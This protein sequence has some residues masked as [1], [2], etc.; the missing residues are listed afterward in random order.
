MKN[1]G[2]LVVLSGPSGSGKD[3][4]LIEF[5]QN[6]PQVKKSISMTTREIRDG[7][8]DGKD[9]YFVSDEE[10]DKNINDGMMLEF[11]RYS[12]SSYGTP[13]APVDNWLNEGKTVILKIE[14]CGAANIKKIY[15]DAV[16]VFITPPSL[17]VLEKRLRM[18]GSED[19]ESIKKRLKIAQTELKQIPEYDYIIINDELD[20][21]VEDFKKII[22]AELCKVSRNNKI[23]SEV[24][25]NV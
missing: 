12:T 15:P 5:L 23:I 14:V 22:D 10:F 8:V 19:E 20:K 25:K 21:C 9:Y 7:E 17:E 4:V 11:A 6:N 18:R 3:T 1:K 13:K 16:L 2:M 24:T